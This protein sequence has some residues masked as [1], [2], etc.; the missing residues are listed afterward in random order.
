MHLLPSVVGSKIKYPPVLYASRTTA[1]YP[2]IT[3]SFVMYRVI[4][5]IHATDDVCRFPFALTH[6]RAVAQCDRMKKRGYA[7]VSMYKT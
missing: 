3:W 2:V 7:F 5:S 6:K 1:D 4:F